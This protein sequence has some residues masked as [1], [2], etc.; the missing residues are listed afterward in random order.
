MD[1]SALMM[2][3]ST[4]FSVFLA[5]LFLAGAARFLWWAA[6]NKARRGRPVTLSVR[7]GALAGLG[8]LV[9]GLFGLVLAF[10]Q[11]FHPST[12]SFYG[13]DQCVV[14]GKPAVVKVTAVERDTGLPAQFPDRGT[15]CA[16]H[17][18]SRGASPYTYVIGVLGGLMTYGGYRMLLGA[19]GTRA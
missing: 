19:G 17:Q 16:D 18:N 5:I 14:C 12:A 15:Y 7:L 1:W 9:V 3:V 10:M 2:A 11:M 4:G 13:S 6:G 8:T